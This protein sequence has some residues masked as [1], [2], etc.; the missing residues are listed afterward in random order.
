MLKKALCGLLCAFMIFG[1]GAAAHAAA[2]PTTA[3]AT[4]AGK[5]SIFLKIGS[6]TMTINGNTVATEPALVENGTTLVPLRVITEAFGA[7]VVWDGTAR[8]ITLNFK[9]VTILLTIGDINAV[10]N[11]AAQQLLLAPRIIN[12][13]TFVPLRFISENFGA[14]VQWKQADQSVTINLDSTGGSAPIT[15]ITTALNRSTKPKVGDSFYKWSMDMPGSLAV[16]TQSF[17]RMSVSFVSSD[18]NVSIYVSISKN[19]DSLTLANI[20]DKTAQSLQQMGTLVSLDIKAAPSGFNYLEANVKQKSGQYYEKLFLSGSYVYTC[21]ASVDTGSDPATAL[22]TVDSFDLVFNAGDTEDMSNVVGGS[23]VFENKDFGVSLRVPANWSDYSDEDIMNKF[24]LGAGDSGADQSKGVVNL[25]IY[26]IQ[27]GLTLKSWADG[28]LAISRSSLNPKL[29]AF[30][31]NAPYTIAGVSGYRYTGTVKMNG[32]D[33][34]FADIFFYY[35]GYAY[36]LNISLPNGNGSLSDSIAKSLTVAKID[37]GKVGKISMPITASSESVISYTCASQGFK[38]SVPSSWS[39]SSDNS[40]FYLPDMSGMLSVTTPENLARMYGANLNS[41]I[42]DW[43][44]AITA[45]EK[46]LNSDDSI[47]T[48]KLSGK[49]NGELGQLVIL[50]GKSGNDAI[51]SMVNIFERANKTF[52]VITVVDESH[53]TDSLLN[54]IYKAINTISPT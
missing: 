34:I 37:A 12:G 36:E 13:R 46:A 16:D 1:Q 27:D 41:P 8:Q 38:I 15:D 18:S 49:V 29:A 2:P 51:Y 9:G 26:S 50:K 30:T 4:A 33:T 40:M 35:E 22:Q 6:D 53:Y 28:D 14:D 54:K 44:G 3:P 47:I 32:E 20:K 48:D 7:D 24:S 11:G 52:I 23:R 17:N 21:D 10:V 5:V 45:M 43:R 19:D 31:D 42:S 25:N 39:N